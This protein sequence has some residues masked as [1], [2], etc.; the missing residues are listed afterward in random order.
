MWVYTT[1]DVSKFASPTLM[2]LGFKKGGYNSN[3]GFKEK[4][5]GSRIQHPLSPEMETDL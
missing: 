4:K 5:V 1:Q 2:G 3:D